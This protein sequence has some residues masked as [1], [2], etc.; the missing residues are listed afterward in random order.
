M[1]TRRLHYWLGLFSFCISWTGLAQPVP[2]H[3]PPNTPLTLPAAA[4]TTNGIPGLTNTSPHLMVPGVGPVSTHG[5]SVALVNTEAWTNRFDD[6]FH[7]EDFGA[8][9]AVDSAGNLIV[10]GSSIDALT[11]Y[12]MALFKYASDGTPLWT[13]FYNGPASGD[14]FGEGVGVDAANNVYALGNSANAFGGTGLALVKYSSAGTALWTNLYDSTN[15]NSDYSSG[16][17][18]DAAGDSFVFV[19]SY[20]A[21]PIAYVTLKFNAL[22]QAVWTNVYHG[23]AGGPDY[24]ESLAL[25]SATNVFITGGSEGTNGEEWATLKYAADGTP[26]WTNRYGGDVVDQAASVKVDREGNVL[27]TGDALN[28]ASHFY[29]TV[30]YSNDGT[31]LW[32]NFLVGPNYQGGNVPEIVTD[33]SNNL[34]ITGGSSSADGTD[35]DFTVVKLTSAGIPVWTNRFFDFNTGYTGPAGSVADAA[36]NFYLACHSTG[37]GGSNVDYVT[38]KY[39]G[40]GVPLWTNRYDSPTHGADY[41]Q[42]VVTDG[43]GAV[44]VTGQSAGTFGDLD[45]ATV[46]YSD[47]VVYTPPTNFVGTD[48]FTFSVVDVLG[49]S[50]NATATVI[51]GMPGLQFNVTPPNLTLTAQGFRLEVDNAVGSN[52][53]LLFASTNL[54]NWQPLLSNPPTLGT[55]IFLDSTA[56]NSSR[57]FYRAMQSQ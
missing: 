10:I 54:I 16:F 53:I 33:V 50:T 17:A 52:Q 27:V 40:V 11:G 31:P 34:F 57:R 15:A 47:S 3:T 35:A 51:V 45:F 29:V 28:G 7:S 12:D 38:V 1:I 56:T 4:L 21:S 25:D 14:D 44:Y 30:K 19:T 55:A 37:A 41:P 2:L 39:S 8:A 32:T 42:A 23:P 26:L 43:A 5:G 22:G 18:V 6:Q 9:E 48:T 13:N 46:K 49:N 20:G 36:G 24:P